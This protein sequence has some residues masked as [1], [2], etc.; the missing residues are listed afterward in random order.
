MSD[1]IYKIVEITGSSKTSMEEAVDNAVQRAAKT[2]HN[3]R[4]FEVTT[5]RGDI[6]GNA[7]LYWQVTLK[8]GFKLDD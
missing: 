5:I 6:D 1:H 7:V 2:L 4:W 3:L 8:A